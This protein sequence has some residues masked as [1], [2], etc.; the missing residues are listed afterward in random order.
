VLDTLGATKLPELGTPR[1]ATPTRFE[2]AL[3]EAPTVLEPKA[4]HV[5]VPGG[6]IK[7]DDKLKSWLMVAEDRIREKLEDGAVIL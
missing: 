5:K 1:D 3:A 4:Q 6:T 7:D 2:Q